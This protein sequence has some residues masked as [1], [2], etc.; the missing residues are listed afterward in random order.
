MR[1]TNN[2]D[3][4]KAYLEGERLFSI[5][6][7]ADMNRSRKKFEDA[8]TL[9]PSYARAHGYLS[10][11]YAR[12]VLAG[13]APESDIKKAISLA[14]KAVKLD[15]N[16]YAPHWDLAFAYLNDRQFKMAMKEYGKALDLY[17]NF[18]DLLDRKHGLLAEMAEAYIYVGKPDKAIAMLERA[19]SIP[20]W[21]RWNLGWAYYNAKEYDLAIQELGKMTLE[22]GD[23]GY[24]MDVQLFVAAAYAQKG[25]LTMAKAA[26]KLFTQNVPGRYTIQ[27]A[28]KRGRFK[29]TT[30]EEHWLDG[31]R[32][33]GL[34]EK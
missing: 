2:P 7:E 4:F 33:A 28:K 17:T 18:T 11:T 8:I 21:Y 3:A 29:Y 15:P 27:D 34:P 23:P 10:Y 30:H 6:S 5:I 22:P 12:S 26:L 25:N 13:W 19:Q 32:K 14:K 31:L 9:D 24:V 20:D 16:D 1:G